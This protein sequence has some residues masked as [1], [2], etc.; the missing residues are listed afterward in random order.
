MKTVCFD[1]DRVLHRYTS[2]FTTAEE[3]ADGPVVGAAQ[4]V[5]KTLDLGYEAVVCSTRAATPEGRA[6]VEDW[7]R[8][9]DFP[10]QLRVVADK[11]PAIVYVDDRAYRFDGDFAD[12]L[13]LLEPANVAELDPWHPDHP[14]EHVDDWLDLSME[15]LSA[16]SDEQAAR[17][18]IEFHRL[19]AWKKTVYERFVRDASGRPWR[20]SC[21][22]RDK[23]M[24]L[25]GASRMGDV[26]LRETPPTEVV[27]PYSVRALVRACSDW[28]HER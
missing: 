5:Q 28:K 2:P 26:F 1:F 18:L 9:H 14:S 7:L 23:R 6:A 11:P 16:S 15:G 10:P 8:R 21:V 20:I 3:I 13:E 17:W 25:S 24:Y 12:L 27:G 19:P 4:A 22:F